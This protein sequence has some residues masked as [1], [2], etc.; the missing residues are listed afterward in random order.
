M[1]AGE[2]GDPQLANS[3]AYTPPIRSVF[4]GSRGALNRVGG[5]ADGGRL[6]GGLV[7]A[8][9]RSAVVPTEVADLDDQAR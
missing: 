6:G 2:Y 8:M 1:R 7:E 3:S 4:A 5:S 9:V